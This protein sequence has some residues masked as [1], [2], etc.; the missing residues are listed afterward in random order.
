MYKYQ[1]VIILLYVPIEIKID[2]FKEGASYS[3]LSSRFPDL[4]RR[5]WSSV[6]DI[7]QR[8]FTY[9]ILRNMIQKYI[10]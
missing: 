8:Q 1:P 7:G 3:E 10:P 6:K 5:A 2:L 4:D 9:G